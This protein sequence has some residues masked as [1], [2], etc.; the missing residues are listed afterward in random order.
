LEKSQKLQESQLSAEFP[1][2]QVSDIQLGSIWALQQVVVQGEQVLEEEVAA[3]LWEYERFLGVG[4]VEELV[5]E[6]GASVQLVDSNQ[7]FLCLLEQAV[8]CVNCLW[9]EEV[10]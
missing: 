5:W 9:E 4:P 6:Q 10:F 3:T 1:L 2:R 7:S 8:D